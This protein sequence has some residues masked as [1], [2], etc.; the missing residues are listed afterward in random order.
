MS[1]E[2]RPVQPANAR[3]PTKAMVEGSVTEVRER[4]SSK[5][6][7][8]MLVTPSG[9]ETLVTAAPQLKAPA[10]MPSLLREW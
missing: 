10:L 4:Q 6:L 8:P 1:T 3:N 7:A 2:V 5:A 9:I